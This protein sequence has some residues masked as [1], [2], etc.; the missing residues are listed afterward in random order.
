VSPSPADWQAPADWPALSDGEVHVW[1]ARLV[2]VP[3][4]VEALLSDDE[5]T[6]AARFRFEQ[7]RVRWVA[8]HATLRLIL[9]RYLALAPAEI[10]FDAGPRDKPVLAPEMDADC[11]TFNL[12]HSADIALVAIARGRHVGVDVEAVRG[13]RDLLEIARRA[14]APEVVAELWRTPVSQRAELFFPAWVRLEA[15]GK[16]LGTGLT[17]APDGDDDFEVMLVDLDVSPGYAGALAIERRPER[18][19]LWDWRVWPHSV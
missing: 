18:I 17:D 14:L 19:R 13:D 12:A 11:L 3:A 8:A 1:R 9:G 10:D 15:R 4:D 7:D 5:Q 2:P 6:R 16:C